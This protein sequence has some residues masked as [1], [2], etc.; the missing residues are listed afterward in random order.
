MTAYWVRFTGWGI[1]GAQQDE[2]ASGTAMTTEN[3]KAF[4][5]NLSPEFFEAVAGYL[6][7]R[8]PRYGRLLDIQLIDGGKSNWTYRVFTEHGQLVLRRPPGVHTL[9]TAHDVGREFLFFDSF[10]NTDVP[11]PRTVDYVGEDSP[12]GVPFFV[13]EFVDGVVA[14]REGEG[15][16]K[17]AETA[18]R[19]CNALVRTVAAIHNF[20]WEDSPLKRFGRPESFTARQLRRLPRQWDG[21]GGTGAAFQELT[22]ALRAVEL[23]KT[24]QTA[25]HGDFSVHNLLLDREDPARILAVLDWELATVGD[26]L[27]DLGWFVALWVDPTDG[28]ER[29]ALVGPDRKVTTSEGFF[30]RERLVEAYAAATG[31]D[32]SLFGFYYVFGLYK[33]A[34]IWQGVYSRYLEGGTSATGIDG[35][36]ERIPQAVE[37]GLRCTRSPNFPRWPL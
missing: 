33:A 22:E 24:P 25:V 17:E 30:T 4:D 16:I 37:L 21:S 11:V 3:T 36:N 1:S 9:E 27:A 26:P 34:V 14:T 13:T 19:L 20:D 29:L 18:R 12:I 7:E 35:M 23:P 10:Q 8:H 5:G 28:P 6:G 2:Q 32:L 31:R 15:F